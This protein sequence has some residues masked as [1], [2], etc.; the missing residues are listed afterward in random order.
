MRLIRGKRFYLKGQHPKVQIGKKEWRTV[1]RWLEEG[2]LSSDSPDPDDPAEFKEHVAR[3]WE[4][5]PA[6][7][8]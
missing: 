6:R 4:R 5:D 2:M 3:I 7:I 8:E 1:Y